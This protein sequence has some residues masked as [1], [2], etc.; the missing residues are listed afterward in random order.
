MVPQLLGDGLNNDQYPLNGTRIQGFRKRGCKRK[1]LDNLQQLLI[2]GTVY[3][4]HISCELQV[5]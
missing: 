1:L 2:A 3:Y 5:K 4:S